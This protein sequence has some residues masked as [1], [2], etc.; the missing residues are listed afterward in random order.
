MPLKKDFIFNAPII[1]LLTTVPLAVIYFTGH[2]DFLWDLKYQHIQFFDN[3]Q[4]DFVLFM[5][6]ARRSPGDIIYSVGNSNVHW[7]DCFFL[8]FE[9]MIFSLDVFLQDFDL[10]FESFIKNLLLT[11]VI[12]G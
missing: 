8:S 4:E 7:I 10:E 11:S 3:V 5:L 2:Y 1:S 9:F 6:Y 12:W